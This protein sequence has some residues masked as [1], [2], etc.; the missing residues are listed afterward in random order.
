MID[1]QIFKM[2]RPTR[3]LYYQGI[4]MGNIIEEGQLKGTRNGWITLHRDLPIPDGFEEVPQELLGG[5]NY[6]GM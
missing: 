6:A 1:K 2:Y 3:I 4:A 5:K